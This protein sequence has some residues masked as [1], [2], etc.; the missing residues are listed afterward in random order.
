[1]ATAKIFVSQNEVFLSD[2]LVNKSSKNRNFYIILS[3]TVDIRVPN[4]MYIKFRNDQSS[5][6]EEKINT[7]WKK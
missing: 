4:I 5:S 7:A 6:F 1:M 2:F 3:S